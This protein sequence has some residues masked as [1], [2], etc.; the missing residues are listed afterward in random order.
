MRPAVLRRSDRTRGALYWAAVGLMAAGIA[1]G[2]GML[3]GLL[4]TILLE[5]M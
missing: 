3:S 4:I 5:A 2:M 1:V